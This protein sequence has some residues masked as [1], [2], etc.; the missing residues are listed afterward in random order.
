MDCTE[1]LPFELDNIELKRQ[2]VS[3]R[4]M[5]LA[6][7]E[8]QCV[9]IHEHIAVRFIRDRINKLILIAHR[10]GWI[11]MIE[12]SDISVLYGLD[13]KQILELLG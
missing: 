5:K 1:R 11:S 9:E 8:Q 4:L 12:L 6:Y 3:E 10:N 2:Y 13:E 7:I